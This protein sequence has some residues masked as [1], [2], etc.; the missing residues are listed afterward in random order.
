M[1]KYNND[2]FWLCT[3]TS[4][5]SEHFSSK[6]F[7]LLATV[8]WIYKKRKLRT[9]HSERGVK[10]YAGGRCVDLLEMKEREIYC[11][12]NHFPSQ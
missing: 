3:A 4:H 9:V 10:N 6:Q 12:S 2:L 11:R 7:K 5:R 1:Q 8:L